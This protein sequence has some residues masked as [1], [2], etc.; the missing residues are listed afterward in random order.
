[1]QPLEAA[2]KALTPST[3]ALRFFGDG[4]GHGDGANAGFL[5]RGS[6]LLLVV[7]VEE[8]DCS[9]E[10]PDLFAPGPVPVNLRCALQTEYLFGLERYVDG[11]LALEPAAL[12][13]APIGGIPADLVSTDAA[14]ILDDAR[15]Q[16]VTDPA[17]PD[18]LVPVCSVPGRGDYEP[19]R[20]L[21]ELGRRLAEADAQVRVAFGSLCTSSAAALISQDTADAVKDRIRSPCLPVD[22]YA[23]DADG[24][25]P[26]ELLVP[27][28]DDETC[29]QSY[30][31]AF[32]ARRDVAGVE[33]CVL[34]QLDSSARTAP[35]GSGWYYDDFSA[36]SER[37]GDFGA[38]L[39]THD[40]D[41][42]PR[43]RLE[44]RIAEDVGRACSEQLGA[45]PCDTRDGD[46]RCEPLSHTC[47][48]ICL[49]D[50]GCG[51]GY[52]CRDGIC[53]NPTCALP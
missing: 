12:V 41:L 22:T 1:E 17:R 13:Y 51:G 44:C 20:R 49:D 40:L 29:D 19:A 50:A 34:R 52:V 14:M 15:M 42:P 4:V 24:Q 7:M 18:R 43:A 23:R 46:L 6:V 25:L 5:R 33:H 38:L 30:P 32:V 28:A 36:R 48:H 45:L 10:D 35:G 16:I 9:L 2:L 21:V 3:S 8:D 26:C 11:L 53:A 47:Q 37:C 27:P 31:R 39:A